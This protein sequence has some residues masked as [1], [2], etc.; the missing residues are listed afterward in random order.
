VR[1]KETRS[2]PQQMISGV[3]IPAYWISTFLW[4]NLSYQPT[5]WML[6]II[7]ASFPKTG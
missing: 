7:V 5:V 1:E 6:V 4:D 2:K 3:S